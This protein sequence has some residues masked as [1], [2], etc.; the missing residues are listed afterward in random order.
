MLCFHTSTTFPFVFVND[1]NVIENVSDI[2]Y[3]EAFCLFSKMKYSSQLNSRSKKKLKTFKT[4]E[5]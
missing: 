1:F 5:K 2:P 3:F 4:K